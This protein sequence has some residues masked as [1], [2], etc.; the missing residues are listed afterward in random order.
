MILACPANKIS[1]SLV[2][3]FYSDSMGSQQLRFS[4]GLDLSESHLMLIRIYNFINKF[5]E[6]CTMHIHQLSSASVRDWC[7]CSDAVKNNTATGANV[8]S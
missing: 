2:F 6:W 5:M 8:T 1:F 3:I 4:S 7:V